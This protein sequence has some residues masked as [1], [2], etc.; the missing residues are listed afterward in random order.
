MRHIVKKNKLADVYP[1]IS[2]IS[3]NVSVLNNPIKMQRSDWIKKLRFNYILVQE[4]HFSLKDTDR[5]KVEG[6]RKYWCNSN[7]KKIGVAILI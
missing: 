5:L 7:Q 3:L 1:T 2:I 6:R 4:T